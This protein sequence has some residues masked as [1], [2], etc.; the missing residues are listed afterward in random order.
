MIIYYEPGGVIKIEFEENKEIK[1]SDQPLNLTDLHF[2]NFYNKPII[3][4]TLLPSIKKIIFGDNFNQNIEPNILPQNLYYLEFGKYFKK[5]IDADILPKNINYLIFKGSYNYLI[6]LNTLPKKLIYL[7]FLYNKFEIEKY[8]LPNTLIYIKLGYNYNYEFKKGVLP[9]KL[10]YLELGGIYSHVIKEVPKTL[11]FLSTCGSKENELLLN[12][13]PNTITTLILYNLEVT[14]NNL[15]INLKFI[16]LICYTE[17]T[18]K[19]LKLPFGCKVFDRF[20][21]EIKI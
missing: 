15:P 5:E 20:D 10:E 19:L 11:K 13:L 1:L 8:V 4:N 3:K 7:F 17:N 12:N 21:K 16:K 18:L 9:E 6:K 14:L 2:G